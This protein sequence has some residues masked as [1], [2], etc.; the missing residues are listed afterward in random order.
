MLI[1]SNL[2]NTTSEQQNEF[3]SLSQQRRIFPNFTQFDFESNSVTAT[4]G[5]VLPSLNGGIILCVLRNTAPDS[6]R[7]KRIPINNIR[8]CGGITNINVTGE[9][10]YML[11]VFIKSIAF[12]DS[13]ST[14]RYNII[15]TLHLHACTSRVK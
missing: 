15:R 13:T 9:L 11:S 14:Y 5:P 10:H 12:N 1:F 6:R 2:L 4:F 8:E 3:F 7:R